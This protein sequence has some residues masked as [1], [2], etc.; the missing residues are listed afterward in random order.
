[1]EVVK[2]DDAE[3]G[4]LLSHLQHLHALAG[5]EEMT[6][7]LYHSCRT[8]AHLLAELDFVVYVKILPPMVAAK[9]LVETQPYWP[10]VLLVTEVLVEEAANRGLLDPQELLKHEAQKAALSSLRSLPMRK[11][12]L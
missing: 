10:D 8:E 3:N 6:Q 4:A 7:Q 2:S 9:I 1:M 12:R 11:L 5:R